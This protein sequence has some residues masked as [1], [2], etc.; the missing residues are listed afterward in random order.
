MKPTW[1]RLMG[2]VA[3]GAVGIVSA[4]L[5]SMTDAQA[6]EP[7]VAGIVFQQDQYMRTCLVGLR[8]AAKEGKFQ[9]IEGNSD[10]KL[11]KE[12]QLID[13][14]IGRGVDAIAITPLSQEGSMAAL[15]RARDKGIK[16][17]TFGTT[18]G[19]DI[20]QASI[21]GSDTALGKSTGA[22]ARALFAKK[23]KTGEKIKIATVAF[24]SQLPQQSDDRV[25]GFLSQ[26]KD[27]VNVVSQQDAWLAEQSVRVTGDI[28]TANPGLQAIFAANEGGTVGAVQAVKNAGL[29]GK[30][31]VFGTDGTEQIAKMLLNKDDVLQASTAQQPF[32][33]G[34]LAGEAAINL[35]QGKPAQSTNNVPVRLL[36]RNDPADL[37]KF[38]AE[39]KK[40]H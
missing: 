22:Y 2:A 19:G 3:L 38:L 1:S 7:V 17:V 27:Q 18:V 29:A 23:M 9:L 5:T 30:V 26:V 11:E 36:S 14:Y 6:K 15:Q 13:T 34:K 37:E 16:V 8:A 35:I 10:N 20:A 25:N 12:A 28:L 4:M 31:L 33:V 21:V 40:Y 32:L 24:K 39:L